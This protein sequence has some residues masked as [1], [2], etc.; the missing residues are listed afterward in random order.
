M[1]VSRESAVRFIVALGL[2][3]LFADVTYEGARSVNG[4]FLGSLGASAF[5]IGAISGAGELVGYV[6]RLVSGVAADRTRRYWPLTIFGY[7]LNLIT[8]PL[9]A[10]AHNWITAA[11]LIVAERAGKAVRTPA[12]DVMLSQASHTIGRGWGFGL[13]E[14]MDQ[15]GAFAG[16]L[17]VALVLRETH[18]YWS[19]YSLLAIP[20]G[21]ALITLLV[22]RSWY[23]DP[24]RFETEPH[25]AGDT[26]KGFP[27]RFWIYVAAAGLV[28]AGVVD[29]PLIAYHFQQARIT[30]PAETP[31]FYAIAMGV[32]GLAA[33]V[34]GRLF[35][36][37]GVP[38]LIA[39]VVLLAA[40][41]ALLFL[42]SFWIVLAGMAMWGAG[43]GAQ[44]ATL[45]AEVANMIPAER[46][47]SA[48]GVFNTVY[49]VLWFAGSAAAGALYGVSA[50]AVV[51]FAVVTQMAAIPLLLVA[52]RQTA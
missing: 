45:R 12:R 46:R 11:A 33:L 2:I 39:G 25:S 52:R 23:P 47:G 16:P 22:A 7:F 13:H 37:V 1:A 29:F 49:G 21:L 17:L 19:A 36:R 3:S 41:N 20:A 30:T 27:T 14:A 8:V 32:E 50:A 34:S 4:P 9:L 28:A 48:Y 44:Q 18:E 5:A 24:T 31:V 10:Q 43:M 15:A 35:D 42:G 26:S 40:S 38:V 6:L 51:A